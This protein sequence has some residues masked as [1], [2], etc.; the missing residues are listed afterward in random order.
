MMSLTFRDKRK[1][2]TYMTDLFCFCLMMLN[3]YKYIF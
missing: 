3:Q 2:T 1:S